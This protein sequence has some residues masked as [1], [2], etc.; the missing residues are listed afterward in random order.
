MSLI[1]SDFVKVKATKPCKCSECGAHIGFGDECL[2]SVRMGRVQKRVCSEACRLEFDNNYW[3]ARA[4][5]R[6]GA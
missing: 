5:F 2:E 6:M 1:G 3:Q 4:R